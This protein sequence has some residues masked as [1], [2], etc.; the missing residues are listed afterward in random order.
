M[1]DKWIQRAIKHKGAATAAA[2]KEGCTVEE[3]AEKHQGDKGLTG[4]QARLAMTLHHINKHE[5]AEEAN[6]P[7]PDPNPG[8]RGFH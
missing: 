2:K 6:E 8:M 3:W 1:A 5:D 7:K 4:Q